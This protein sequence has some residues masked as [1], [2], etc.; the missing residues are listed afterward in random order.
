MDSLGMDVAAS[1]S[2]NRKT[3]K[4]MNVDTRVFT[5]EEIVAW[6]QTLSLI[7]ECQGLADYA[8]EIAQRTVVDD[9][10]NS[11]YLWLI[12]KE[13]FWL[14]F[15][16]RAHYRMME[17]FGFDRGQ[18]VELPLLRTPGARLQGSPFQGTPGVTSYGNSLPTLS[19]RHQWQPALTE[20]PPLWQVSNGSIPQTFLS[21]DLQ[22]QGLQQL[23]M[24]L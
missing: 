1:S 16:K 13:D 6:L 9:D 21:Q 20:S 12:E 18:I 22:S 23:R 4:R 8:R 11:G 19:Q 17:R 10:M 7:S 14:T 24:F 15:M 5:Y 3:F 2:D